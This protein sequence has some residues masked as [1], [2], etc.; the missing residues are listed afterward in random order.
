L[1]FLYAKVENALFGMTSPGRRDIHYCAPCG[2]KLKSRLLASKSPSASKK[3]L[4]T[5][6]Y[7]RTNT[8][9]IRDRK[10]VDARYAALNVHSWL[11][12]GTLE[13]RIHHGTV[14]PETITNWA[15]LWATLIDESMSM[16]EKDILSLEG[17]AKDVLNQIIRHEPLRAWIST[18]YQ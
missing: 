13:N 14:N 2:E 7:G 8:R 9:R 5:N 17:N 18:R 16:R 1:V 3:A 4:L 15:L 12:R 10:Y 6:L 11:F